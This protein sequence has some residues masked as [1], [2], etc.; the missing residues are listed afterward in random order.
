MVTAAAAPSK[1]VILDTDVVIRYKE[2]LPLLRE[3]EIPVITETSMKE[4]EMVIRRKG[5]NMPSIVRQLRIIKDT[6]DINRIIN[7]RALMK[8][9][10]KSTGRRIKGNIIG[11]S[12]NAAT[13]LST[14]R[15]IIAFDKLLKAVLETL[16]RKVR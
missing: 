2:A 8:E 16:G 13:A 9:V 12:R 11:D 1:E 7:I 4:L 10:A 15:D 3:G 14:G 6:K 5:L